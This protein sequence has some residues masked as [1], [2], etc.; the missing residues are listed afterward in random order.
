MSGQGHQ[1]LPVVPPG[2]RYPR[3]DSTDTVAMIIEIVFGLFGVMGMGWIYVGNFLVGI[4]LFIGWL[5]VVLIAFL[6]PTLITALTVGIGAVTYCCLALM[7]PAGIAV[8]IVSG[9]RLKDYVR[10]TGARGSVLYLL[11]AAI[12][13]G[14]LVCLAIAISLFALG[15]LAALAEGL[16]M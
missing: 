10:N 3:A 7:P 12:V 8:A 9:I 16:Q 13:G 14:L 11:I 4:G 15:G 1:Q 5:V 2:Y 6:S